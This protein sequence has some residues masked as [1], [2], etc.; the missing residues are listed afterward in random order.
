MA[1]RGKQ[2]GKRGP[3]D[4]EHRLHGGLKKDVAIVNHSTDP[5]DTE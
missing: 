3:V 1:L 5:M 2:R 4:Q